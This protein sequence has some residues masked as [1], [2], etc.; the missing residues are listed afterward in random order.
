MHIIGGF[1]HQWK[2]SLTVHLQGVHVSVLTK[3]LVVLQHVQGD[4]ADGITMYMMNA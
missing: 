2:T 4:S 3:Q 1:Y